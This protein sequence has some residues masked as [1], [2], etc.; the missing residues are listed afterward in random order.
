M[1]RAGYR[2]DECI[3]LEE[4]FS[5][6][7]C[8]RPGGYEFRGETHDFWECVYIKSGRVRISADERIY[9]MTS[10]EMIFHKPMELHKYFVFEDNVAELFIFS[11]SA[12]GN[13]TDF[14]KNKVFELNRQ[15]KEIIGNLIDFLNSKKQK[16]PESD[17][18]NT[19]MY[20]E[21]LKHS[22]V[23]MQTVAAYV[24]SLFLSI[25]SSNEVSME[26]DT[27]NARIFKQAVSYMSENIGTSLNISSIAEKCCISP[28][29]LKKIFAKYAG[30]GVHKYFLKMK[31][32]LATQMLEQGCGVT[33]TAEKLG[34]SGQ[35]YFSAA[36]KR[37][38]GRLPSEIKKAENIPAGY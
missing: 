17:L 16:E 23:H 12:H 30:L 5:M 33:E 14:F 37:E 27:E 29:G 34:F 26:L 15:Q 2:I 6:F 9:D 20:L 1:K 18:E 21:I 7:E 10:G 13:L 32:N 24:Y 31:I 22:R 25:S 19:L 3:H 38:T 11:F 8:T 28:T 36:Y 35:A 4:F